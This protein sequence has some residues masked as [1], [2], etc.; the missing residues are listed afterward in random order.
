MIKYFLILGI[1]ITAVTG[2]S[3]DHLALP[4]PENL[5]C[6]YKAD[7]LGIDSNKPR[8]FWEISSTVR[9]TRQTAYQVIVA[10]SDSLLTED[11]ANMWNS[12]KIKSGINIQISYEGKALESGKKYFWKVKIWDQS[13]KASPYSTSS[14]WE[15]AL[16]RDTDWKGTWV[17]N[18]KPAPGVEADMYKDSPSPIFRKAFISTKPVSSARLYITGLGYY[19]V[20]LNGKKVGDR[21]LDPGWTNYGKRI[22]YAIYDVTGLIREGENAIGV[23]LGNGW[24][25]PLPLYLFNRLNLRNVLKIGQ[26][27]FI[28]QLNL[29]HPD[30]SSE[31]I[32]SNDSWKTADGPIL[33]NSVYLGEKYDARLEK[34]GW[35]E[36]GFDDSKWNKAATANPP[37]GKL[38]AQNQPPVRVTKILKPVKITEVKKGIYIYDLGQ[39]FAGVARLRVR[40]AAGSSVRM[41]Y[42]E[43]LHQDGTLDDRSTIACH[44]ME[45]WY[46]RHR[47]GAPLNA[48][49]TDTYILKGRGEEVYNSRF[50]FHGFRYVEVTGFPGKPTLESLEGLRM[51]SDLEQVGKFEC[52]DSLLN[53]IQQ[54]TCWTFLSNV[55]SIESDCPGREKFGYG[56]DI[57]AASEAY[58]LNY[59][60]SDF[61]AKTVRDFSNDQRSSGGMPECAPD[62]AIYDEGLTGDTGPIGWMLAFPWVQQKLYQYYGDKRIIEEEYESTKKLIEFI[63]ERAPEHWVNKGISD[64]ATIAPKPFMATGTAFYYDHVRKLAE[65]ARILGKNEDG[66][67]YSALADEIKK[68]FITKMVR[69]ETGMVDSATQAAQAIAVYYGL[70]PDESKQPA[71]K[72]LENDIIKNNY[73]LST[74][75]FGTKFL[76]EVLRNNNLDHLAFAINNQ[77]SFPSYGYMIENGGTTIWENWEGGNSYNHPMFGSVSEWFYKGVGGISP[78]DDAE[79]FS[80]M[81]IRPYFSNDLEWVKCSYQSIRG[82]AESSW[83]RKDRKLTWT[84][85]IPGN[86]EALI[87]FPVTDVT[88]ITEAGILIN[89][90]KGIKF[91][92]RE[93]D[94]PVFS[95]GGGKYEFIIE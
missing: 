71:L 58:M 41:R 38:V 29:T 49:Q 26:P 57:V 42:G 61:Y 52:S 31:T 67:K 89:L 75:I 18:G 27:E 66:K 37:G 14:T 63:R 9:G 56:G 12:G 30:G 91:L 50:T 20:Y 79:G 83:T 17:F 78:S 95:A 90:V 88:K 70:L 69:K 19:E 4:A 6:E 81:V 59:N 11:K 48:N 62:N 21:L 80:R 13:G 24:F 2:C 64:H 55:F 28:A 32:Y 68:V 93:N 44:I 51:N 74:G 3:V 86:T 1:T 10:D 47:P 65:F 39:N 5:K 82:M 92:Y 53:R 22:Q 85:T 36:S 45:G 84:V 72:I 35:N 73:H 23:I 16:L 43:L 33:M 76:F 15:M 46:V 60:M 77:K 87:C 25:N 94:R 40:G 8:L 34:D 7:P 54:N